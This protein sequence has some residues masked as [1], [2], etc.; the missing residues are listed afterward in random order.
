MKLIKI[1][2]AKI[3]KIFIIFLISITGLYS[4]ENQLFS[5][6]SKY[7]LFNSQISLYSIS[8][9]PALFKISFNENLMKYSLTGIKINNFFHRKYSP[10]KE[11]LLKY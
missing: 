2:N 11:Q 8:N 4:F 5:D 9:N 6:D 10:E 1:K 3:V 7:N